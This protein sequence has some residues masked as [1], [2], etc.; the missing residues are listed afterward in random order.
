MDVLEND[1]VLQWVKTGTK[2]RNKINWHTFMWL[3]R[4]GNNNNNIKVEKKFYSVKVENFF[5]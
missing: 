2:R 5:L 3:L 4:N 1:G